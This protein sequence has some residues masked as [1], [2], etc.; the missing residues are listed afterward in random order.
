MLAQACFPRESATAA[1]EVFTLGDLGRAEAGLDQNIATLGTQGGRNGL[2]QSLNT[3]KKRST[4]L[5]AELEFLDIQVSKSAIMQ[6]GRCFP[7]LVSEAH[8]LTKTDTGTVPGGRRQ[9]RS[10]SP[11]AQCALHR[12]LCVN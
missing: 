3:G 12:C 1:A 9:S 8:L 6:S 11:G 7:Y 2:G 10:P 4:T 5:D